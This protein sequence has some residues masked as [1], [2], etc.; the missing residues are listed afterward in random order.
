M[1][2]LCLW[3]LATGFVLVGAE[4][5]IASHLYGGGHGK[6]NSNQNAATPPASQPSEPP[7]Q[8]SIDETA[9]KAAADELAKDQQAM[10]AV[11]DAAWSQYQ[12]NQDWIDLQTTLTSAQSALDSAKQ[13]SK[14]ALTNNPDYQSALAA[15]KKASDDLD[16]AKASGESDP[17]VLAPLA[18]AKMQA[19]LSVRTFEKSAQTNDT[20][21]QS[22]SEQVAIAQHG[23]EMAKMKFLQTLSL[24]K[25]YAAAKAVVAAAQSRYDAIHAK[26]LA[27][28]SGSESASG[29]N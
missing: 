24:D 20:G 25:S 3:M 6:N 16:A 5:S 11:S 27:D 14:D 13:A 7:T 2:I 4:A 8:L 1:R 12:Q 22:A 19:T 28:N 9:Q 23:V 18:E 15:K 10:Q 29:D 17:N 26:V 21:V